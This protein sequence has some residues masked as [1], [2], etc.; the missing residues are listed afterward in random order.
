MA[1]PILLVAD[2]LATIAAV[3]R[4]LGREG[5]EVI[6]ATSAADA[7]IAWGHHLPGLVLLQPSVEGERGGVVLEEL[8]N[9]PDARLLR[10]VLL[11]ETIP[12]F[13]V[14]VEPLPLDG[15]HFA[16][17]IADN[18]R[19]AKEAES[20]QVTE[21]AA[22]P[23][24]APAPGPRPPV[25]RWRATAPPEVSA[26]GP[27]STEA[28]PEPSAVSEDTGAS[29]LSLQLFGDLAPAD[30]APDEP[31]SR[32][33]TTAISAPLSDS[34]SDPTAPPQ[35]RQAA[36]AA[37][38]PPRAPTTTPPGPRASAS[39]S[40]VASALA[41]ATAV[42]EEARS[43]AGAQRR[44]EA[45]AAQEYQN[46]LVAL[47]REVERAEAEGQRERELRVHAEDE[48]KALRAERGREAEALH[49]ARTNA[50]A[51]VAAE[52]A[53]SAQALETQRSA[54]ERRAADL[55]RVLRERD[56]A[57]EATA[58]RELQLTGA[59][60]NNIEELSLERE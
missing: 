31:S 45:A 4:V 57:L 22:P 11:G 16:T 9:H 17:T 26:E 44:A 54:A 3:K 18:L 53:A 47:G 37:P 8:Q 58:N 43:Q 7:I 21:Q 12:G 50:D 42:L 56:E 59:L 60:E 28:V 23:E 40:D 32:E 5:Y 19:A 27:P 13:A 10:V 33:G 30:V 34:S 51:E 6:L 39:D 29:P 20:W 14:E 1:P 2:D 49:Q 38:P 48:L 46:Q 36:P 15:P 55:E 52:R 35:V 41:R 24:P 25:E